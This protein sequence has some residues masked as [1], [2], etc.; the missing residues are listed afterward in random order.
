MSI[1]F[2]SSLNGIDLFTLSIRQ[3]VDFCCSQCKAHGQ[4]V[5]HGWIYKFGGENS[6]RPVGKR[7]ICD[8]RRGGSG[9]GATIK[10]ILK[11]ETYRLHATTARLLTFMLSLLAGATIFDAYESATATIMSRNA[12][13]WW[14]KLKERE[15]DIRTYLFKALR[16]PTSPSL[17][18]AVLQSTSTELPKHFHQILK[19]WMNTTPKSLDACAKFQIEEQSPLL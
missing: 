2:Q 1:L 10:I 3:R 5:P 19:S 15:G 9:C 7:I 17:P 4:F 14:A 6:K 13:R 16:N 18:T 8:R 12:W 11:S